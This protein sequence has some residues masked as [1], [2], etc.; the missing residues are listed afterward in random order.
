M[1]LRLPALVIPGK[2]KEEVSSVSRANTDS[3]LLTIDTLMLDA[4][5]PFLANNKNK[6]LVISSASWLSSQMMLKLCVAHLKTSV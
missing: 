3:V 4:I 2:A 5:F 6:S 1:V